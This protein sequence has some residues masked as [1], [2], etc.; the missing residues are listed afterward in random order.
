[1]NRIAPG[2][3]SSTGRARRAGRPGEE[4]AVSRTISGV[5]R[6]RVGAG[7][8]AALL[9]VLPAV[10]TGC[11][12]EVTVRATG[13][14][15]G[16]ACVDGQGSGAACVTA[17]GVV[18]DTAA[19]ATPISPGVSAPSTSFSY[20]G[21][22][23]GGTSG[24]VTLTGAVDWSGPASGTCSRYTPEMADVDA[25]LPAGQLTVSVANP[26]IADFSLVADGHRFEASYADGA[27]S[28][29]TITE[30]SVQVRS[31]RLADDAGAVVQLSA[32][33]DC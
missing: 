27:R 7:V 14:A 18:A 5:P 9:A 20:G 30:R 24:T 6:G 21:V 1:M 13:P 10:A 11:G 33:F 8:L 25:T 29:L 4:E 17:N 3:L 19:P 12:S 23:Q 26:S 31:V 16:S 15:G 22:S 32:E 2:A 28:V